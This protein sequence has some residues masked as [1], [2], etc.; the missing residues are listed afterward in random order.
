MR[1]LIIILLAFVLPVGA[2]MAQL[3]ESPALS[4]ERIKELAKRNTDRLSKEL[5]LSEQQYLEVSKINDEF[6]EQ[7]IYLNEQRKKA[8][9]DREEKLKKVLTEEQ[10]NKLKNERKN[11]REK[12]KER[13][14]A[15]NK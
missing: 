2:L 3:E 11:R 9:Q 6:A 8:I 10:F 5:M 1:S 12:L 14:K 15:R 13:R 7:A 4:P